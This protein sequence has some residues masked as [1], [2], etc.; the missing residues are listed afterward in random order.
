M[1]CCTVFVFM[2]APDKPLHWRHKE[3]LCCLCVRFRLF[4]TF[5]DDRFVYMLLE[6]C[7]GG[8]LWTVLRDMWVCVHEN[9]RQRFAPCLSSCSLASHLL[10]EAARVGWDL[11]HGRGYGLSFS[12]FWTSWFIALCL[13]CLFS[14]PVF[15]QNHLFVHLRQK[16]A[17][18]HLLTFV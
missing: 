9:R 7:L 10:E 17:T 14:L 8:E 6:A 2:G 16:F 15:V 13:R 12:P 11:K 1:L 5:R 18:F 3:L 4:R